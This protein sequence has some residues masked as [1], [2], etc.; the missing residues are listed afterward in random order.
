MAG[1]SPKLPLMPGSTNGYQLNQT[2][3]DSVKQ[4][5][6][7]LLLTIPGER[8]MD[9]D[10]GVGVRTYLFEIDNEGIRSELSGKIMEQV[11]IYL[12]WLEVVDISFSS[13]LED[14][15]TDPNYLF[16]SITYIITPLDFTDKLDISIP[17]N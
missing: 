14:P 3:V 7:G 12:P 15:N 11:S 8:I 4:N 16:M 6:T 13:Q 10:F 17:N 1:I 9:P 5:L 2:Y